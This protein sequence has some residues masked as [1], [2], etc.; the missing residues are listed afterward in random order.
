M[1]KKIRRF[2]LRTK[3][4]I[5]MKLPS[6]KMIVLV[7]LAIVATGYLSG[8][9]PAFQEKDVE[10]CGECHEDIAKLHMSAPHAVLNS[11][12]ACHGD[13]EEHIAEGGGETI[14][15]FK[16]ENTPI[17]KSK[18][19]LGCHTKTNSRFM[20]SPHGKAALDCS[21]CHT[22]H[23]EKTKPAL[24]EKNATKTCYT[25]HEDVFSMFQL[26]ERHRL[27]EGIMGCSTCHNPHEPATRERLAG[28]K[29]DSCL[30]CHTDKGGPYIYE[31]DASR[32]EGCKACH[33]VHGSPNRRM[34]T[35][36][37]ISDLCF[38]CHAAAP[39]WHRY[40]D[41]RTANCTSCHST[42]HGSNLHRLFLK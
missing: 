32:I 23:S 22:V 11:C 39:S 40:F 41:S 38:S 19:C 34:L 30:K 13:S 27:Q 6:V 20:A 4:K 3:I 26:N 14:F 1:G 10:T 15:A 29:H 33:E 31:H 7:G 16:T 12:S 18:K 17:E 9:R 42:I 35:H 21:T 37:S 28:F 5:Q 24:L 36:Q 8:A 2:K 25:C